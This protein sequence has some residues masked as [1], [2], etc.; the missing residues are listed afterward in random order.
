MPQIRPVPFQTFRCSSFHS[1][2]SG[3]MVSRPAAI[4]SSD[5]PAS[6]S[7]PM[8][9]SPA[10][11]EKQS[12]YTTVFGM[13]AV[14]RLQPAAAAGGVGCGL[15][16]ERAPSSPAEL[17]RGACWCAVRGMVRGGSASAEDASSFFFKKKH[18]HKRRR[19]T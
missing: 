17:A 16:A 11:P 18:G 15:R 6:T 12:K 9:M 3:S 14:P 10:I 19:T 7:A 13:V 8:P 5:T 4:A 1:P 2:R